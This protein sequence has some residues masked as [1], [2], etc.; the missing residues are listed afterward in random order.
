VHSIWRQVDHLWSERVVERVEMERGQLARPRRSL[1]ALR[2]P[3]LLLLLL[4]LLLL[5]SILLLLMLVLLLLLLLVVLDAS[6]LHGLVR[7]GARRMGRR[8]RDEGARV[9]R[10][11]IGHPRTGSHTFTTTL[12][13][14]T[15][16][17]WQRKA[18]QKAAQDET[19]ARAHLTDDSSPVLQTV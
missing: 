9:H 5:L 19:S 12:A 17:R 15:W 11:R 3:L 13:T 4:V 18:R 16:L 1:V 14:Q 10:R 2:L 8:R 7:Q 6:G